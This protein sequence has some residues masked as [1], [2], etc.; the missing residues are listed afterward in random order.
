MYVEKD[1]SR[2]IFGDSSIEMTNLSFGTRDAQRVESRKLSRNLHIVID[3]DSVFVIIETD[4]AA[5][6]EHHKKYRRCQ[7]GH[8]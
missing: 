6:G 3:A 7:P 5:F 2:G 1:R 4:T 8:E